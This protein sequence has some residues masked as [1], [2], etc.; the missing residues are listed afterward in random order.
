MYDLKAVYCIGVLDFI[1]KDYETQ[2][3][4]LEWK[5]E[6]KL[7][8]QNGNTFYDKLTFLFLTMPNFNKKEEE[9]VT[10]LDKWLYFIKNLD[11]FQSIPQIFKNEVVFVQAF[12][13]AEIAKLTVANYDIYLRNMRAL[14]DY[15]GTMTYGVREGI[16]RELKKAVTKAVTEAVAEAVNETVIITTKSTT[17]N[18]AKAMKNNGIALEVIMQSTLLTQEE[19]NAL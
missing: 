18:I 13:S 15:E 5:H 6:V 17:Q 2:D 14:M 3:E 1:F 9:L 12:N 4:K 16:K 19:I 11:D 8:D 7:K 10:R